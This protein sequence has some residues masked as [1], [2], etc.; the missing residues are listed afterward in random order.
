MLSRDKIVYVAGHR[1]MVGSAIVRQL[2]TQGCNS[3]VTR[4]HKELDLTCQQEVADFFASE[5]ID[6]VIL[7]AA[8]VGGIA[9]NNDYPA[10]FI[11]QNL[12]IECNIIHQAWRAGVQHLLFLGSSCIYP[13][14]AGQPLKEEYLL[15]GVLEPTNEPYALAKISGI[16][17]CESY[18]R[19]YGTKYRSVM[20]TNLFGPGDNYNLSTSHVIPAMIR[21]H[22]LAKLAKEGA[23][24]AII[25]DEN[26]Y[27]IIPDDVAEAIGYQREKKTLVANKPRVLLWGTG[28][29]RREFLHVNDMAAA[30]LRVL[31]VPQEKF[32]YP[33]SSFVNVG[34][35]KD[36]T[37]AE[38]AEIV[39]DCVNF[40]G[41]TSWLSSKPDGT[42][43]KLLDIEKIS[44]LGWV[45]NYDLRAGIM[46]AYEAYLGEKN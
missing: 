14:F 19:Q 31:A 23:I 34:S 33:H 13:K 42:P 8:K 32:S 9:A 5:K 44:A 29:P 38:V 4:T 39:A 24:E 45:P 18:N 16:K 17:M 12:M 3:I 25:A 46:D 10:D 2:R 40:T 22:H 20:P 28:K 6:V 7:A 27:G 43:Q 37:I 41:E 36:C 21:K 11:Y 15:T 30:C 1:G 35:G 26:K